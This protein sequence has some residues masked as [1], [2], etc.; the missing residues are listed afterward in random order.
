M[1]MYFIC[2]PWCDLYDDVP[3]GLSELG[4]KGDKGGKRK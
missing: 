1:S 4:E 3:P 2:N